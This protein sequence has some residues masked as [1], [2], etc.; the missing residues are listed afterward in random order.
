MDVGTTAGT[1]YR[2]QSVSETKVCPACGQR[3]PQ[4]KH[5]RHC[6]H[7]KLLSDFPEQPMNSDGRSCYCQ[8]CETLA[9]TKGVKLK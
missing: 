4:R 8:E 3:L 2:R 1:N 6:G 9:Q 7:F 5:C